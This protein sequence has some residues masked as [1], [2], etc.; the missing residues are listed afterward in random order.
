MPEITRKAYVC[1]QENSDE[2]NTAIAIISTSD[3]DRDREIMLPK[4]ANIDN[5]LKAPRVLWG[6]D[7]YGEPIG[8][9]YWVKPGRKNIKAKWEWAPTPEAQ[10]KRLLWDKGFLNTV[11]IGFIPKKS[12][13]PTPAEI[14]KIPDWADARKII[15]EWELLEFSV[16]SVPANPNALAAAINSK[17][18]TISEELQKE[19]GLDL[20]DSDETTVFMTKQTEETNTEETKVEVKE[21]PKD[22]PVIVVAHRMPVMVRVINKSP[23]K[24]G[25][26]R[27]LCIDNLIKRKKGRMYP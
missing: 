3:I 5:W 9:G 10:Q 26:D 16:V 8:K 24:V 12:H 13:E 11:S 1:K 23:V 17:S 15:D 7:Y 19:L 27:A 18:I 25:F 14:K 20:E 6:H 2:D 4:G 22:K 21:E